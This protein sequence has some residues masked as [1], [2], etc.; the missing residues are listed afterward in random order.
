MKPFF[1]RHIV[2]DRLYRLGLFR[3]GIKPRFKKLPPSGD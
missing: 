1:R 2:Y 3:F